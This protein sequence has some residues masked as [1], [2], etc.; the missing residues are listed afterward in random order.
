MVKNKCVPFKMKTSKVMYNSFIC[1][2]L[3]IY[4]GCK[5]TFNTGSGYLQIQ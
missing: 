3:Y 2:Y 5:S 4:Q 1:K